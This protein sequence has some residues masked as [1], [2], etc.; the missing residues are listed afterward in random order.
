[1]TGAQAQDCSKGVCVEEERNGNN[2]VFHVINKLAYPVEVDLEIDAV[3]MV[4]NASLPY[5]AIYPGNKRSYALRL[6]VADRSRAW[7][8]EYKY[9]WQDAEGYGARHDDAYVY[10]LPYAPAATHRVIQ[11]YDGEFSHQGENAIDWQMDIGTPVHAAREGVVIDVEA[12]HDKGGPDRGLRNSANYIRIMHPDG[13]VGA[14]FH[15][16]KGGSVVR[17][18]DRVE[19]RQHIGYSGN[20]GYSSGPHLHFEV[21]VRNEDVEKVTIPVTFD[22]GNGNRGVPAFD[23]Q[24]TATP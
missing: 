8:Y 2:V 23:Q 11:G 24:Y 16:Q 10:A 20:T 7:R 17:I 12:G 6:S 4:S 13:S 5:H 15:L 21:Y 9:R 14:Y 19:K 1:M 18:G 3:N 22:L